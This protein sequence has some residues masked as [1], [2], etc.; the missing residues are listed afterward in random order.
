MGISKA[1]AH[2]MLTEA[3]KE[4][5]RGKVLTF[6]AQKCMLTESELDSLA[7]KVGYELTPVDDGV[8]KLDRNQQLTDVYLLKRLGFSEIVRADFSDFEGAELVLDLNQHDTPGEHIGRYDM[9]LDGGTV[10]HVFHLPNAMN[11]IFRFLK[12]GGRVIHISPSSNNI[13]H[14]F[15]MFSPSLFWDYY[16]ANRYEFSSFKFIEYN[17]WGNT[18]KWIAGDYQPG[19]LRY[20]SGGGLPRG[21]YGIV[22]TAKKTAESTGDAIPQMHRYVQTWSESKKKKKKK[23]RSMRA[24][25]LKMRLKQ[26]WR[27]HR[28]RGFPLPISERF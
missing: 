21:H 10:E 27:R 14:G 6:G 19:C 9:L 20:V 22:L 1:A 5:F 2:Y 3:A 25:R 28:V 16:E 11:H 8:P 26:F 12:V 23:K 15:Y 24:Y 18:Q 17:R 4:P 13:D 7:D